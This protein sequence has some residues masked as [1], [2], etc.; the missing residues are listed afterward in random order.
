MN[1]QYPHLNRLRI[2]LIVCAKP[3]LPEMPKQN[4]N[5]YAHSCVVFTSISE[6]IVS[7]SFCEID[8]SLSGLL[9]SASLSTT[10]FPCIHSFSHHFFF[11]I[12]AQTWWWK[13]IVLSKSNFW[14]DFNFS[15]FIICID[16]LF[17]VCMFFSCQIKIAFGSQ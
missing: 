9:A 5:R 4:I 14:F 3:V 11:P 17:S 10:F 7:W 1:L 16:R 12:Y 13:M 6:R 15:V 2:A 8:F